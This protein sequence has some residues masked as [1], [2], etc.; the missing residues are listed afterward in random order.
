MQNKIAVITTEFLQDFIQSIFKKLD[1]D[2]Q[3]GIFT[4]RSFRDIPNLYLSLPQ[5]YDGVLT[6][7]IFP[8]AIIMKCFP[9]SPR[10]IGYFNSDDSSICRL[11]IQRFLED[12]S[13]DLTRVYGDFVE[14]FGIS[15]QDY[16]TQEQ[17]SSYT[18]LIDP[19]VLAMSLEEIYLLEEQELDIHRQLHEEG[20][21]DFSVTRFS[22]IV[23]DLLKLGY[24]VYFPFPSG[25]FVKS[26]TEKLI[27]DM[28]IK[29]MQENLPAVINT[30]IL[31]EGS[32]TQNSVT[33]QLH[34][35]SL[36]SA[37]HEFQG[38]STLDY[39]IQPT[40]SGIEIL[41]NKKTLSGYTKN[42]TGCTLSSFLNNKLDFEIGIGYG[43]GKDLYQAR[44]NAINAAREACVQRNGSYLIN[45]SEELRGPLSETEFTNTDC[46]NSTSIKIAAQNTGLS[47]LTVN[48]I[49][50]TFHAMHNEPVTATDLANK[51]SVTKRSANRFLSALLQT[52]MIEI[53]GQKRATTKGRPERVYRL[54][55]DSKK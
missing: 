41:T 6:S 35:L 8:A 9:D 36:Q 38:N 51:L 7:G 25:T 43:I 40:S 42:F 46:V 30:I 44:L 21:V 39:I 13:V 50:N 52:G 5:E 10:C 4:Y 23:P 49:I 29:R 20:K 24:R 54:S 53:T 19:K 37:L 48:R 22:S 31:A 3:I 12:G 28:S 47:P 18:D 26:V 32:N 15:L 34:S 2:I 1:F 45:E 55:E 16:L 33:N 11:F 14:I 27:Q 17:T